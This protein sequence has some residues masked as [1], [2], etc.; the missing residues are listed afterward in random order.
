MS[1]RQV[2]LSLA[3]TIAGLAIALSVPGDER[4]LALFAYVLLLGAGAIA[5]LVWQAA[6]ANPIS[7]DML[8]PP[9]QVQEQRVPQLEQIARELETVLAL[10]SDP[11]GE[12]GARLRIVA[13]ARL[14][15]HRG[16]ELDRQPERARAAIDDSLTWEL[17]RARERYEPVELPPLGAAE[18]RRIVGSLEQI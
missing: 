12:L 14:A 13:S 5:V 16:I 18:L 15:D 11:R 17:V 6:R 9:R 10:G 3:G 1:P 7:A 2:V 4:V 8:W